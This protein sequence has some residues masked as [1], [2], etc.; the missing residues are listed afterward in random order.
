M[1]EELV[2]LVFERCF[3]GKVANP[4]RTPCHLIFVGRADAAAGGA[5]LGFAARGLAQLVEFTVE[6]QDEAGVSG[7]IESPG[8]H[9]DAL[10]GEHVDLREQRPGIDDHPVADH[11]KCAGAHNARGQKAQFVNL[12]TD[13]QS[14]PGIVPALKADDDIGALRQPIDDL[15]LALIAPLRADDHDVRHSIVLFNKRDWLIAD[16]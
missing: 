13:N 3:V 9:L 14:V 1:Q 6:R 2:D 16:Q 10:G 11:R 8:C 12:V 7:N 4:D 15:A 5:N